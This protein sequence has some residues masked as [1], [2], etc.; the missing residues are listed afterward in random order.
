M[1]NAVSK[2]TRN[3]WLIDAALFSSAVIAAL[4]GIYFLFLPVGGYQGGRNPWAGIQILFTR[5]TWDDLHTWSGVI[6]I[7]A[8]AIHLVVHWSWVVNMTRRAFKE[9]TRG[10]RQMN[11]RGRW[12]LILNAVVAFSFLLAALSGVYFLFAPGGR[13]VADPMFLFSRTTWDLIHT[14]AGVTLVAAAIV[15][16]AIHWKWVTK[17]TH[18]LSASL[19][20]AGLKG[21]PAQA[22]TTQ[23]T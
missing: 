2:Q 5:H 8:A 9:L 22:P 6:M 18:N 10:R 17:V 12:N 20:S 16:F 1:K 21:S 19:L 23:N 15:H 7:A 11:A 4:S 14:W 3:N 13:G